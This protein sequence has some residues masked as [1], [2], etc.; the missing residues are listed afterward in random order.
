M[1]KIVRPFVKYDALYSGKLSDSFGKRTRASANDPL[2]DLFVTQK[3]LNFNWNLKG[4]I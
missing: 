2:P 1:Y 3:Y 4:N